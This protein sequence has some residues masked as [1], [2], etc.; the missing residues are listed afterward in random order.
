MTTLQVL[1]EEGK[2]GMWPFCADTSRCFR[3]VV[4]EPPKYSDQ[5]STRYR[6]INHFQKRIHPRWRA[7][8]A[9][10]R[11]RGWSAYLPVSLGVPRVTCR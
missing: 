6:K 9:H 4:V 11:V 10:G 8:D 5:I 1:R 7:H 2:R 3:R